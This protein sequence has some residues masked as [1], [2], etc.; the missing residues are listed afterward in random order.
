[1]AGRAKVRKRLERDDGPSARLQDAVASLAE[2]REQGALDRPAARECTVCGI[3]VES[4]GPPCPVC[5]RPPEHHAPGDSDLEWEG[6]ARMASARGQAGV[7]LLPVDHSALALFPDPRSSL[8]P[9]EAV[10]C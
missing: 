9:A 1:M 10:A 2:L 6:K 5:G 4:H 3:A 7:Q 8:T